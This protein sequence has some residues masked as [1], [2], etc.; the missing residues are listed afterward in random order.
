VV[1]RRRPMASGTEGRS[2]LQVALS[3]T[4]MIRKSADS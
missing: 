2:A 4:E 1:E 3:I